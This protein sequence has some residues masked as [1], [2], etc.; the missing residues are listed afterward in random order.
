MM[1]RE[2]ALEIFKRKGKLHLNFPKEKCK[3]IVEEDGHYICMLDNLKQ[4]DKEKQKTSIV[5]SRGFNKN[6]IIICYKQIAYNYRGGIEEF[7]REYLK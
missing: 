4:K 3:Q 6:E 7:L 1:N 5:I 2:K